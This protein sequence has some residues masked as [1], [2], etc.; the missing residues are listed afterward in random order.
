MRWDDLVGI[1][2]KDKGRDL[3]GCDC[4]GLFRMACGRQGLHLPSFSALYTGTDD[5]CTINDLIGLEKPAWI[6]IPAGQ[7]R[8]GDAVVMAIRGSQ[9]LGVVVK[10]SYVLHMPRDS[11]SVV[12]R[13]DTARLSNVVEGFYRHRCFSR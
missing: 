1:P 2:F 4:Y 13:Y 3:S 6:K 10:K 5:K 7:E 8:E 11:F 12:E 9:H